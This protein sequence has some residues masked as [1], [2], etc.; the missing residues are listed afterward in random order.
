M[1]V[2]SMNSFNK[3]WKKSLLIPILKAFKRNLMGY[4]CEQNIFFFISC[5]KYFKLK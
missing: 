5:N 1:Q 2:Y 4:R 3:R